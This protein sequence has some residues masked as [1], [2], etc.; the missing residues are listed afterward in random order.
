VLLHSA[1]EDVG[2]CK[3]KCCDESAGRANWFLDVLT[4]PL[5]VG[6]RMKSMSLHVTNFRLR[7]LAVSSSGSI[8]FVFNVASSDQSL[9]RSCCTSL[10]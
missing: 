10:I 7:I 8:D 9:E 2:G 3:Y 6:C 4:I 5:H 1:T